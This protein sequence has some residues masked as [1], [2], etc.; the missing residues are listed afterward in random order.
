M[1]KLKIG[2]KA[3]EFSGVDQHGNKISISDFAGKT[4]ILFFYP[5]DNT[6]TCTTEACDFRDNYAA[7]S[8]KGFAV[9]GVSIDNEKSHTKFINKYSLPYTLIADSDKKMVED[10]GVWGEKSMYG[11]TYMGTFRT[12]FII[13]GKGVITHIIEKVI[14]K[15]A[16][17]QVLDLIG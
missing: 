17:Q 8:A 5:K 16:A 7:L 2:D 11:R 1:T 12:T 13:D 15:N 10:Y 4:I 9:I 3:P 14:S 6:P